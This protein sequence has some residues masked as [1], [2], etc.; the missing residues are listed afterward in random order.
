[1][2]R[3]KRV[4]GKRL[5]KTLADQYVQ[6]LLGEPRDTRLTFDKLGI[7][8][9]IVDEAHA[10]KNVGVSP[11]LATRGLG[12]GLS[13]KASKAKVGEKSERKS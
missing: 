5:K 8:S 2:L 12:K 1:M 6:A 10:F 3:S 4:T 9:V 7:D 13:F 11:S